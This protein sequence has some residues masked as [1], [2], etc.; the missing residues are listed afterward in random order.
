MKQISSA[1]SENEG[2]Y[3]IKSLPEIH[4]EAHWINIMNLLEKL[5]FSEKAMMEITDNKVL[6]PLGKSFTLMKLMW[7]TS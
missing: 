1:I 6:I 3:W 2:Q 5:S 4:N 7:Y